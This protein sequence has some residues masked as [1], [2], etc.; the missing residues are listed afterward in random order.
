MKKERFIITNIVTDG[1]LLFDVTLTKHGVEVSINV[2]TLDCV[3]PTLPVKSGCL[4][5]SSN[6]KCSKLEKDCIILAID[7]V[8][9]ISSINCGSDGIANELYK[10]YHSNLL[11]FVNNV[12]NHIDIEMCHISI[13][14]NKYQSFDITINRHA[15]RIGIKVENMDIN[16]KDFS[17]PKE[18]YITNEQHILMP[19]NGDIVI[20][21]GYI[22]SQ[23]N[24][25]YIS[26]DVAK[27]YYNHYVTFLNKY[28]DK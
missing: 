25:E 7:R 18:M 21:V 16:I 2:N 11:S 14:A 22:T 17:L 1:Q 12:K 20:P 28:N 15:N 9:N 19:S 13:I 10:F 24:Q 27:Q 5:F 4:L 6:S 3:I 23:L 26:V 8:N